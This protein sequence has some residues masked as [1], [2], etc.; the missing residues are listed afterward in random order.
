LEKA[1]TSLKEEK[2]TLVRRWERQK[3][4]YKDF[5]RLIQKAKKDANKRL[6]EAG[7]AHAEQLG[8]LV[9]LH[10]KMRW[11]AFGPS[12]FHG[13]GFHILCAIGWPRSR[14][15]NKNYN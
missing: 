10:V 15:A 9:P 1:N 3:E 7:Q 6:H 4:A 8:Q 13:P 2:E 5:L 14:L 12:L 11:A